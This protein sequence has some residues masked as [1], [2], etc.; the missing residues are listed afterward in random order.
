MKYFF[1]MQSKRRSKKQTQRRR[2]S[3]ARNNPLLLFQRWFRDATRRGVANLDAMALATSTPRG[4]PSVRTLLFKGFSPALP[5]AQAAFLY[6][7]HWDGRKGRGLARN[8]HASL[9]FYWEKL[10]RQ[11]RV[12]G[13]VVRASAEE[14][15]RY[16]ASRDRASQIGAW[17][18]RQ[19]REITGRKELIAGVR[20]AERRF[21]HGPV[22]RPPYWGGFR[23]IPERIEFWQGRPHRLH[24]RFLYCRGRDGRWLKPKRLAP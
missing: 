22:P 13:R 6:F 19:S 12:E 3:T 4:S 15:D 5:D 14:S 11:I 10:E 1:Q 16:F 2:P 17:A 18:A 21:A 24:D 7:S 20:A 23:L 8:P 9:V